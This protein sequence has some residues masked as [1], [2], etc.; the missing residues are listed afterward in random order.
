MRIDLHC[1]TKKAKKGDPATREIDP[2]SLIQ[3]LVNNQ[4]SI[5]AIT[6][7]NMFDESQY[8][9]AVELA[10]KTSVQLWPGIELD[11]KGNVSTGHCLVISDPNYLREFC[12]FVDNLKIDNCDTFEITI[13][14]LCEIIKN[15]NVI[16]MA[17]FGGKAH[18]LDDQDI[19]L[20]KN[21]LDN[22]IPFF[23]EPANLRSAGIYYAKNINCLI[24]SDVRDWSKYDAKKLPEL[25]M[26]IKDFQHFLLLVKKDEQ[27]MKTFLESKK[28]E[29]IEIKPF[30]DC[31]L[32]LPI[33]NDVNVFF[34]GKGTGKSEIVKS[35]KAYYESKGLADISSY[36]G[37]TK[38]D[39]YKKMVTVT[40]EPNDFELLHID[41]CANDF[42]SL[43]NWK[44]AAITDLS[45]YISWAQT[46]QVNKL[47]QTF[48]F[49]N[50]TFTEVISTARLEEYKKDFSS[51]EDIGNT[52]RMVKHL[53][54]YLDDGEEEQF[55]LLLGKLKYKAF[56]AYKKEWIKVNSLALENTTI[57]I[58]K[59][60]CTTKS[61]AHSLPSTT[62]L[63]DT[64]YSCKQLSETIGN[65]SKGLDSEVAEQ[66]KTIGQIQNKGYIYLTKEITVNP[67][68][69]SNCKF[70]SSVNV[71]LSE[72][73]KLKQN[74]SKLNQTVFTN[75]K[76][77]LLKTILD[78]IDSKQIT[79][80]RDF[81][82]VKGTVVNENGDVYNPSSGEQSMLLLANSLMD[83]TKNVYFLDEPELSVGHD[84][85][86][87]VI[88]P[89]IIEL[90]KLNKTIIICTHDANIAV[91]TLP[92]LSVYRKYKGNNEYASYLGSAFTDKLI[93]PNDNND[94]LSWTITSLETLEG[95]EN[96]FIER[97]E[98]YG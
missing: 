93:N 32:M 7:H 75:E 23:L 26:P 85:I 25:K 18:A 4:V 22:N 66:K 16:V 3:I 42:K 86:N 82:R 63:K 67:N 59:K 43:M 54:E 45:R 87:T 37:Q 70:K 10:E 76:S 92:L 6:N 35:I 72:I 55:R 68:E 20:L 31:K 65:I 13:E 17:H 61:G 64:Y 57:E 34:G 96:A 27:V 97:C 21:L 74:L 50:A 69:L 51:I 79:S 9:M 2:S 14:H 36:S 77:A 84:Y 46:K 88:V 44:E 90:A 98:I 15:L 89:K 53:N 39:D 83:D 30:S 49:K 91:R 80:L 11:I 29:D 52:L 40:N 95:G 33:Y 94:S 71:T 47:S 8:N 56:E 60:L 48:G 78:V 58:M 62:G 81:I 41:D 5:A 73:R 12:R 19:E 24:G 1:H 38:D 28:S